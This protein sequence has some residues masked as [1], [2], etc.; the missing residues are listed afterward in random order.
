M[1]VG[2][3]KKT[4]YPPYMTVDGDR[5]GFIV[6]N[7]LTGKR[8]RFPAGAEQQARAAAELLG[9]W[10]EKERQIEALDGGRPTIRKLV[11]WWKRD[12]LRFQP[13]DVGT[14]AAMV[15]KM[16]RIGRELGDRAI[17]RTDRLFLDDWLTSFCK[18][19]DQFNKW[20]YALILLWDFAVS[21]KVAAMCEPSAI[22]VRSTSKKLEFNRKV[23]QPL[24]IEGYKAI[25]EAAPA[26][27]QL[28]M[29]QSLIT[30]QARSEI[31]NM[32][33][34]DY[35][36]GYLFVIR[37]KVSGDSDMAF[38]KIAVTDELEGLRR[39]SLTLDN[40]ASPFLIHRKPEKRR[41]QWI[42]GKA[43][44]T[45][46]NPSYLSK[47]F[48]EV[49]D[50]ID[51]FKKM[52]SLQRPSFHEIRGLGARLYRAAGITENAIQALMT[53]SNPRTTQIY[54]DR[55]AAALSDDEY[56][57]VTASLTLKDLLK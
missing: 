15:A 17:E 40:T 6:R 10:L 22:E 28:A 49:R 9:R 39:R 12:R 20:R 55:G 5:G 51:R 56:H 52:P 4:D 43:H 32:R 46:V 44:W 38:I 3:P 11:E 57:P 14:R 50:K 7:P 16:N 37:D 19:G 30:L 21:R 18:T 27:L 24:D 45:Y 35:R 48:A 53:H 33:Q 36:D 1:D 29:D 8:K 31:C 47:A 13:W 2:R 26:W 23:R 25:H 34:T 54:L 42:E 41:R